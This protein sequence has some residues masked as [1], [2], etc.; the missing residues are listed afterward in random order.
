MEKRTIL[1]VEDDKIVLDSFARILSEA[2]HKV[3]TADNGEDALKILKGNGIDIVL[4]DLVMKGVDGLKVLE[5]TKKISPETDVIL[6]TGYSSIANI[7]EALRKNAVDFIMKPCKEDELI[8]RVEQVIKKQNNK[9]LAQEAGMYKK[10]TEMLGAVAHEINNP[11]TVIMGLS[12]I[13][14]L[15]NPESEEASTIIVPK[16]N[17]ILF[18][19]KTT[20]SRLISMAG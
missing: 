5:E 20:L 3:I 7:L 18:A 15:K 1:V 6:I 2:G 17:A 19:A 11:L 12:E 16:S 9:R 14:T 10:M 13:I 8:N 4:S